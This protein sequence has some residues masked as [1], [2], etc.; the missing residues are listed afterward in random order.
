M[1]LVNV[2]VCILCV[3]ALLYVYL[4]T[5]TRSKT[6]APVRSIPRTRSSSS[7]LRSAPIVASPLITID[8]SRSP[9]VPHLLLDSRTASFSMKCINLP[10]SG[11]RRQFIERQVD[12]CGFIDSWDWCFEEAIDGNR[13]PSSVHGTYQLQNG[14][15]WPYR[16]TGSHQASPSV[17]GCT[18]SHVKAMST[19]TTDYCLIIEDDAFLS[20]CHL[21][22]DFSIDR[23]LADAP[24]DW[25]IL[26]LGCNQTTSGRYDKWVSTNKMY[27]TYAYVIKRAC[28]SAVCGQLVASD[29]TVHL[30]QHLS[31]EQYFNADFFLYGLVNLS[32]TFQTY[33]HT[34]FSTYNNTTTMDST[35]HTES[36]ARHIVTTDCTISELIRNRLCITLTPRTQLQVRHA[37]AVNASLCIP[38]HFSHLQSLRVL[39]LSL[40]LQTCMTKEIVIS[41][42]SIPSEMD[43]TMLTKSLQP[44]VP[45]TPLRVFASHATQYAGINRN[46]CIQNSL[47]DILIFIDADDLMYSDRISS[48]YK[49]MESRPLLAS[50]FHSYRRPAAPAKSVTYAELLGTTIFDLHLEGIEPDTTIYIPTETHGK[51]GYGLKCNGFGI[52]NGHPVLRRSRLMEH[53]IWYTDAKRGQDA[54]FNRTILKCLGRSDDTMMLINVP[55]THYCPDN[56]STSFQ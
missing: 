24:P 32:T 38:C 8:I 40:H 6:T 53:A 29:G 21:K 56:S 5:P 45:D 18:L 2:L 48:V 27:G 25:G 11:D 20:L 55:Y 43:A 14:V 10:Q 19:V 23:I 15:V 52:H 13:L 33:T 46:I 54:I 26:Q 1:T 7:T 50:L 16:I 35:L 41:V 30:Q 28:A 36:T 42:S 17:L 44:L 22:D 39:L 31:G 3:F 9:S 4:W 51:D 37:T 47:H 12:A 49:I 34:V